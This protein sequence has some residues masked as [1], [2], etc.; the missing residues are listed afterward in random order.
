MVA[1]RRGRIRNVVRLAGS[2]AIPYLSASF[3]SKTALVR[4]SD[5]LALET[6]EQTQEHGIA[7]FAL[8]PGGVRTAMTDAGFG[9]PAGRRW[10]PGYADR[11]EANNPTPQRA[12]KLCLVVA[13]GT[14][15]V[16]AGCDL[17]VDDD[18]AS[19]V[20]QAADARAGE[21]RKLRL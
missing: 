11:M 10:L 16:L 4:R 20:A 9:F 15:D 5:V 18:L 8:N 1:R 13:S 19:L 12:V 6:Q 3:T 17:D 14:A 21:L 2:F 7:V